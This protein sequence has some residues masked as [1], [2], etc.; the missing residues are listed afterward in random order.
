MERKLNSN[1]TAADVLDGMAAE[2]KRDVMGKVELLDLP[3]AHQLDFKVQTKN[4][5]I[6]AKKI[7]TTL[8]DADHSWL[9][10]QDRKLSV[11]KYG[12]PRCDCYEKDRHN[13]IEAKASARQENVRMAVGQLLDYAFRGRKMLKDS[14]M[15]ALLP[16]RPDQEIEDWLRSLGINLIWRD[17]KSFYDNA[18][19]RFI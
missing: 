9:E 2:R 15:A 6:R 5:V 17:G 4:E 3:G 12:G 8:V 18:N 11:A 16:K 13:L 19:G 10:Q 1:A 14:H 7:E